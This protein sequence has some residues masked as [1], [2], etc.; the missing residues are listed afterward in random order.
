MSS[1]KRNRDYDWKAN[2]RNIP[3]LVT[4]TWLLR[5]TGLFMGINLVTITYPFMGINIISVIGFLSCTVIGF[6]HASSYDKDY[7][8]IG[9]VISMACA[10]IGFTALFYYLTENK[11]ILPVT[12]VE[13]LLYIICIILTKDK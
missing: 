5:I 8:D 9:M 1:I 11:E 3:N 6:I 7:R 10:W 2:K 4:Y 12:A 13:L